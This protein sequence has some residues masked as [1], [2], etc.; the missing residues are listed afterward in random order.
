L[1]VEKDLSKWFDGGVFD[2]K[3]DINNNV[4]F[5]IYKYMYKDIIN[6]IKP[7][8]EKCLAYLKDE[9]ATLRTGRATPALVETVMVES[10]GSKLPLKQLAAIN[11][12][13]ARMIVVQPWDKTILKEIEK[14]IRE[15]R[16]GLAPVTEGDFIRISILPLSEEH[17]K[18]LVRNLSQKL[19]AAKKTVRSLR[20]QAWKE[21]QDGERAGLI[22][23][24]D[25]FRGKDELQ[26][27][28]DDYNKKLE[29]LGEAKEKEIMTI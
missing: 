9:M 28:I 25:K 20:E 6:K 29:E 14:A 22:R 17:R 5:N 8:L 26:K 1:T 21:I 23:E 3:I 19:E 16:S 27:L 24:D 11:V 15:S 7:Q 12:P 18:E 10:Y 2:V 13:D 4:T